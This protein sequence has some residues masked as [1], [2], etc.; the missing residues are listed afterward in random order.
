MVCKLTR[1]PISSIRPNLLTSTYGPLRGAAAPLDAPITPDVPGNL[2][3][4]CRAREGRSLQFG[5]RTL[6][7]SRH[8]T[9]SRSPDESVLRYPP[10]G[11]L[12]PSHLP[13]GAVRALLE[14]S[15]R[16]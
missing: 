16:L 10:A 12:F 2:R 11:L 13:Q 9:R 6:P 1:S 3:F 7:R 15:D 4:R 14:R 5:F 8:R